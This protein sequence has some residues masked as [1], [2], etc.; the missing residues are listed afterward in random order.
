[1]KVSF[2][3]KWAVRGNGMCQIIARLGRELAVRGHDVAW[4]ANDTDVDPEWVPDEFTLV[5]LPRGVRRKHA[6]LSEHIASFDP[7]VV[8]AHDLQGL[9]CL[10]FDVPLVVTSHSHW[11]LS[12]K[13]GWKSALATTA[14]ECPLDVLLRLSDQ[15]VAVSDWATSILRRRRIDVERVYNGVPIPQEPQPSDSERSGYLT[16]GTLDRRKVGDLPDVWRQL[17]QETDATLDVVGK[18]IS[19]GLADELRAMPGVTVHGMVDR[20]EPFY[21]THSV[22]LCASRAEAF[23]LTVAEAQAYGLPVVAW[24]IGALP[25]VISPTFGRTVTPYDIESFVDAAVTVS[26]VVDRDAGREWIET[27]FSTEA[28]ATGYIDIYTSVS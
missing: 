13:I 18:V 10:P 24:D 19:E 21:E 23:G 22:Y 15:A 1:M 2:A 5:P 14:I 26:D 7:D 8:H 17:S 9:R 3:S 11:P 4:V 6:A 16:V 20:L 28:M 25:E 27:R 12:A